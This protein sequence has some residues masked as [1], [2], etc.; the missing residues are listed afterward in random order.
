MGEFYD[1]FM[2]DFMMEAGDRDEKNTNYSTNT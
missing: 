1:K 2:V